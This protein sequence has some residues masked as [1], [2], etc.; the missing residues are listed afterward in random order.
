V[1]RA[2]CILLQRLRH[3]LP[4][5]IT[6][7]SVMLLYAGMTLGAKELAQSPLERIAANVGLIDQMAAAPAQPPADIPPLPLPSPPEPSAGGHADTGGGEPEF[8]RNKATN[9]PAALVRQSAIEATWVFSVA[10]SR[11]DPALRLN[12]G[13]AP[14]RG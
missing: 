3:H 13:H 8:S 9:V 11:I 14:P 10:A 12:P 6:T 2:Q 7:L 5:L 4:V 1:Q